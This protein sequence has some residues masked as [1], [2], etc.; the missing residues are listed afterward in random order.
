MTGVLAAIV[1]AAFRGRGIVD[2]ALVVALGIP[3]T[4]CRMAV[5]DVGR[6]GVW[7]VPVGSGF[8][9]DGGHELFNLGELVEQRGAGAQRGQGSF[10]LTDPVVQ[11]SVRG[12]DP[13][14][15]VFDL[16]AQ[17]VQALS[18]V[19]FQVASVGVGVFEPGPGGPAS[20]WACS[21]SVA[22]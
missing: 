9:P 5:A 14:P 16:A 15:A 12:D 1:G 11:A 6:S 17:A 10:E 19:V 18:R 2:V 8:G 22:A 3:V 20:A 4:V 21:R 7:V 13:V